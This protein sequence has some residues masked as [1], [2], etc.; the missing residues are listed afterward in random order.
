MQIERM[1]GVDLLDLELFAEVV[2]VGSITHGARRVHLAL[3]SASAR[4]RAMEKAVG[5]PLLERGRRGVTPTPAGHLL[6]RHARTVLQQMDRMRGD[7][8][9]YA[10]GLVATIRL[11]VNTATAATFLPGDLIPFLAARPDI[12][13]DLEER[14]SHQIVQAVAEGRADMGIVAGTVSLGRL[15]HI[16]LRADHLVVAV[17]PDHVLADR[18][19]ITYG[20]CLGHPFVGLGEGSALQE[21]LEG[22]ALPLGHR[23]NYRVRLP[24]VEAVCQT[25]AAGVGIAVLP[26]IAVQR[27]QSVHPVVALLLSDPWANRELLLCVQSA[28]TLSTPCQ[29]LV[30]HLTG[31]AGVW[32]SAI[33]SGQSD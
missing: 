30:D 24:T 27:W 6:L 25:V 12:D 14:P 2:E 21:H 16:P 13:I 11:L 7:L 5:A 1:M 8:I 31:G 17:P 29:A 26:E 32:Q 22:H 23:P 19:H 15:Q 20:E 18:D 28:S 10:D 9:Q 33:H 3:P 4:I